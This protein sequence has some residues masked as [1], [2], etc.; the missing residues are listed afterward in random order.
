MKRIFSFSLMRLFLNYNISNCSADN[1]SLAPNFMAHRFPQTM[2]R[3]F[4]LR[5]WKRHTDLE[6]EGDSDLEPSAPGEG[7]TLREGRAV[8]VGQ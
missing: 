7:T 8:E 2:Y 4:Q 3:M 6:V 5:P 1:L